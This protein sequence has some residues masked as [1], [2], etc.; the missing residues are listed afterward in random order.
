MSVYYK[1]KMERDSRPVACVMKLKVGYKYASSNGISEVSCTTEQTDSFPFYTAKN[2]NVTREFADKFKGDAGAYYFSAPLR[3][4]LPADTKHGYVESVKLTMT[5]MF[6]RRSVK[7]C[8]DF[9]GKSRKE[10]I[11]VMPGLF[12]SH[13]ASGGQVT[14]LLTIAASHVRSEMW[15][16]NLSFGYSAFTAEELSLSPSR[17]MGEKVGRGETE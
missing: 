9:G 13:Y 1:D 5:D 7:Y 11:E 10:A 4:K 6:K 16:G 3:L 15:G 12:V 2:A 8:I 17:A 14:V